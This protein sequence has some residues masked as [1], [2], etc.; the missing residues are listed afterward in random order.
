[1][2]KIVVDLEEKKEVQ[3]DDT[4]TPQFGDYQKPQK[5]SIFFKVLKVLSI[6]LVVLI[7]ISLIS[8]F[9]YW[10][11]LKT[12]PQYSLALIVDAARRDDQ[13]TIDNLI[14]LDEIVDDFLPQVVNKAVELYGRGVAPDIIKK[15]AK[16]AA[17][18]LPVVKQRAKAELPEV[19]REKTKPFEKI[20]FWVIP[21]GASRYLEIKQ[22]GDEAI[23]KSKIKERPLELKMK[24]K[25]DRWQVV[26]IKDEQTAQKIARKIGQEVL[27]LAKSKNEGTIDNIGR[28]LGIDNAKDLLKKAEDIFK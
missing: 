16:V 20:P 5:P 25:G 18:I 11:Y 15:V 10:R 9:F 17:P 6:L 26:A 13:K 14:N 23:V 2:S 8:G 4:S 28:Q 22:N 12:T 1:M 24:R 3:T 7:V 27:S 21:I 19:L